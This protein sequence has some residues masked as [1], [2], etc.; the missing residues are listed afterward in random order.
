MKAKHK[1][2][3]GAG[4]CIAWGMTCALLC[5][6]QPFELVTDD[7]P[8]T[9]IGAPVIASSIIGLAITGTVEGFL[10]S[11]E[12]FAYHHVPKAFTFTAF[13]I[14]QF[15]IYASIGL[16]VPWNRLKLKKVKEPVYPF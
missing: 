1:R 3:L 2:L 8:Y 4:I 16:L 10:V 6:F 11:K 12:I 14:I 7:G 9:L 13:L 5:L 15:I